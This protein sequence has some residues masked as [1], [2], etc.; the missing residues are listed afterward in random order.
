MLLPAAW[1]C[2]HNHPTSFIGTAQVEV[3]HLSEN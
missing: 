1:S 2:I 3:E